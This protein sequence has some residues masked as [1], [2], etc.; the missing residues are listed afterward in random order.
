MSATVSFDNLLGSEKLLTRASIREAWPKA[1]ATMMAEEKVSAE[2]TELPKPIICS[3]FL[4]F[5]MGRNFLFWF[6]MMW[7]HSCGKCTARNPTK[8]LGEIRE[9]IWFPVDHVME[10]CEPHANQSAFG[11]A[12]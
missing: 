10:P 8:A 3:D 2:R 7:K 5:L 6:W 1:K 11:V 9:E 12:M 4:V